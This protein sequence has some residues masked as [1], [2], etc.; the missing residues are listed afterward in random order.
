MTGLGSNPFA[1]VE[2]EGADGLPDVVTAKRAVAP[3]APALPAELVEMMQ[4]G[5]YEDARR[6]LTALEEEAKDVND[7]AYLGYLRG[8]SERLAGKRDAARETLRSA[9][10][11]APMSRWEAKIR[12]ELAGIEL[13]SGNLSVAEQLTRSE[14]ERLLAGDRKDRLAEVYHA[15]ARRLLEPDDPLVRP[16]PN[17]AYELLD[18]AR[19]LAKSALLRARF[20]DAMGRASLA[21]GNFGRA[22]ENFQTYLRDYPDG[23]DRFGVRMRLGEGQRRANQLLAARLTWTDLARAIERLKP[24]E[25]TAAINATFAQALAEIPSTYGI[26]NPP[27]DTSLNLGVAAVARFLQ[28][29]PAHPRAVREAFA[30]AAAYQAR[31]KHTQALDAYLRFLKEEGFKIETDDARRDWAA[32]SMTASYRVGVILQGQQ[33]F[34]EA[35]AAWKGY[36]ARFPNGPHGAQ[37]QRAILDTQLLIAVDQLGRGHFAEARAAWSEFV[38]Q[39][40]LDARLP[41]ILFQL[42][43]SYVKEKQ[44]DRAIAAWENLTSKFPNSEPAAHAQFEIAGIFETEKG[45]P[46]EA[47]E[48]FKKITVE[49]WRSQARQ[50]IAVMESKHLVTITPRTFRSGEQAHLEI[51]TRNIET[52]HFTAY[53]L[54]AEAYFRK[55]NELAN[56]ESLDIGLVAPDASWTVSVPGYAR[57]KPIEKS[58][59]LKKLELPGV[60]VVKV[61]D[62]KTFQAT[63]LVVGSDIDAIVK[64][65]RDQVLVFA[66]DMKTG[67]GRAGARVLIADKGQ[68][69]LEATT[70][71]DGI[72]LRDWE[73][74][75]ELNGTLS[76]LILDGPHVAGSH[77]TVPNQVAQGLSPRAY[78]YTD[79]PAYRPGQKVSVR[80]VVREVKDGQYANVP[81]AVY[82]FE[83]ADSRGRIIV[84]RPVALSEFG[85]FHESLPLD[86]SAPLGTYRVTVSQP[87]KSTFSGAFEVQSY[88]L[89]PIDLTFDVKQG[90]V[91]RGETVQTDLVARYQYGAP[92]ASRPIEI[93]LPDGRTLHGLTDAA[94]K[95]HVEFSTEGFAEEQ[96]LRLSARL[97]QDNVATAAL[98][99][100]AVRG[101]EIGLST[102]RDVYLDGESFP[103]RVTTTD[104]QGKPI[105]ES[106]TATLIKQVTTEG[107]VTERDVNRKT[108]TTDP[109]TGSASLTFRADDSQGGQYILRVAGTD[110]FGTAIVADRAVFISGKQDETKLRLLTDRQSYKVGEEAS[111]NLHSRGRAGTALLTW[112]ADRILSYRIVTL[113]E[114]DNGLAWSVDGAQF[115]N[116]TLT[117]TRMWQNVCDEAKLDI[118]VVRDL[119]VTV[120]PARPV[121][122]PGDPVELDITAVDQL[123]HAV[124]A[125]LSIAMV[126]Q[127]LLRLFNDK[128]PEIGPFFYNQTR[129]GAFSTEATNTFRYEPGTAPVSEAVV[130]EVEREAAIAS[131]TAGRGRVTELARAEARSTPLAMPAPAPPQTAAAPSAPGGG[132]GGMG[133]QMMAGAEEAK[134]ALGEAD[135]A[136]LSALGQATGSGDASAKHLAGASSGERFGRLRRQSRGIAYM[137][138]VSP[139]PREKYVETAYWNPAVVTDKEGKARITFKA[140]SALSEYRITARGVTGSDTLAGQ[141]SASLTVRKDFSVNLKVPTALTQ[142]DKPRLIAEV[143]HNG[144]K[145]V[146]SLRLATYAGG[147]DDVFLKAVELRGDGIDDVIF[148]PYEVP[149]G[150]SL[151]LTLT[152]TVGDVK[153]E[154][155]VE[156]LIHPWGIPVLASASGTSSESTTVFLGLPAGRTYENPDMLIALSPT[157]RRMLVE[158]AMGRDA[159]IYRL[160]INIEADSLSATARV[161]PPPTNTTADRA[162]DLLA[163]TSVLR[164]LRE[165]RAGAAPEAQ[166]LT[167]RIQ[168][169]VAELVAAQNPDGGWPWVAT[170]PPL[171]I[172]N[173]PAAAPSSDRLTSA[174]V[175][176]ALATAEPLGLSTD[177]KVLDQALA[178]LNQEFSR[179][180]GSDLESRAALVHA[181]STR[182]AASFET[183]NSLNRLRDHLSSPALAYLA[184][185]FANLDRTT[186]AGELL[187]ILGPRAKTETVAPGRTPRLY[188]EGT[189]RSPMIRGAA[190][191]TALVSLAYAR[192]RPQA[193]ELDRA[194]DWLQAHRVADGWLPHKAKGPA[195]ATL[196]AYYGR[197]QG[198]E[199]R[200]RLTVTVNETRVGVVDV[201]G[202]AEEKIIAV[203]RASLKTGQN[204]RIRFEMEGRGRFGYAATLAGFTREF[205]PDQDRTGRVAWIDRRVYHPASPELDGKVLPVGFGV[206]VNP[207]TFE[208]VATQVGLGGKARVAVTAF[209]NIPWN[210]PEW[211]RDF[212]V[213]QDRLPAGT[214]LI[215]GS[216]NTQATSYELANG[217]L[218]LYFPPGVNPGTTTYDV[219]GYLP[220]TYRALP[221]SVRS[222]YEPGRYHL[223]QPGEL[224][225]RASGEPSTDPYKP[226]P[227]EL[228]AW[229][230]AH[231]D[232]GRFAEAGEA[233]EPLYGGYTLRDDI[234][235][236][237]A[238]ML[239]LISIRAGQP[240][241]IVQYFEVVK[242]KSPELFLSFDQLLAIGA[243][244]RDIKEYERAMIVWRGL[245]EASYLEDARVG[246]LLRQRGKTLEA[247]AYLIDLWRTYPNTASIESDFFGLSQVLTQAASRAYTDPNLRREQAAA[248]I[249]RSE[250][251]LQTIRMIQVFLA[252]S[253]RNPMADEASLALLGAFIEL[254][255]FKS[256]VPL[257][258]RFAR[259]YPRSTYL[260]SFQYSEAL[261]QFHLG[262]YDRAIEVA[263]TI[264]RATYKDASGAEQPSPNKWQALYILG[265]IYDARRHPAKALEYYRQVADR[266]TDAAG[267]IA[268]YT[269][270]DLKVP[271]VSVVRPPALPAVAERAEAGSAVRGLRLVSIRGTGTGAERAADPAP[272]PGISVDYR[273]IAQVDVKA[274][275]VDLMQLYLTRRN[276]NGIAGIDLAGITPLVEKTVT[277]GD[278]ADYGD[279]ARSIDLPL[280]KDG[281][282]LVMLRGESLYASGIVLVSPIEMEVLEDAGAGR[283]RVTVRDAR[284]K[285]FLPKV[286]V[287]VIGSDN[288]QFLSGQTDLR[289]VF[290]ASGVRGVVTAVA[291]QGSNQYAFYRGTSYVGQ[292]AQAPNQPAAQLRAEP[293]PAPDAAGADQSLD[294]N[295]RL[296]N[297]INNDKQIQRLQQRYD[298]PAGKQKG[299]AAGGFR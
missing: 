138:D 87:G 127:S 175:F 143:H 104:A 115:P 213:V 83:V 199:D 73:K 285:D 33:K 206:A 225:V 80:G 151:R 43:E 116:F 9:L 18:Q 238:R 96:T 106:L 194:V 30:I 35:I 27:D 47:I 220:G 242:E 7:R 253:P 31:G 227:D 93:G 155:A 77:L 122:G 158:L 24:T 203:P 117:A 291:R 21:A 52:L 5:R 130:E 128:L 61:T 90:V 148:E 108:L 189:G 212:L 217:V 187:D 282:Y 70:G 20:L 133:G 196:S 23:A 14:A 111:V 71:P 273:N 192:V 250:L 4:A 247:T 125:E 109:T 243:A 280:T 230:K 268:S 290:V 211:E 57:Y 37:A 232:A 195:L 219:Y 94:G 202:T 235:K 193:S 162:A 60:Y 3:A 65:S 164:Y 293:V 139:S 48:R 188:W 275:P 78:I 56:V 54:S 184:L 88:Q 156:I 263:G 209:R 1:A 205:A 32:L 173:R 145:G 297:S 218:T 15:F 269:R 174:A 45:N 75:R 124:S 288:P 112:E 39:N 191:T 223:G 259:I 157:L 224:R 28:A 257:A 82:R 231:F 286:E 42:G 178:Y 44:F 107:R 179:T 284:S 255:D 101:F 38:A 10:Q 200:Y 216:V 34:A 123:G 102:P 69:V 267:A 100:L 278:G 215:E 99:R 141:T 190:E 121:V 295:L 256:V 248:G 166:R 181:M 207:N 132:M 221:A 135:L 197:A 66:Q 72:L 299:A 246:E 186:M 17:A 26:P 63:T 160:L 245:I 222:A 53:K 265:Q 95:Y 140:P 149:D 13:A 91:Y 163:A 67:R 50:R 129:T 19:D 226:T 81:R 36:L 92:L 137:R 237:A 283:V 168:G 79:R 154:L 136:D 12:F 142:G 264:A 214:T 249:T 51:T 118:Q 74:P 68:V 172:A 276:L 76:Y 201:Q 262:E 59:D 85:T 16:D 228:F 110:R 29:A 114:G 153:D 266:F 177:P 11:A 233:L 180:H 64:T 113:G 244:Y 292:E 2:W 6:A 144:V 8:I 239:L 120:K 210:V 274:Y 98:V 204:N 287:K 240:R 272:A 165:A 49:P 277:L 152:G 119:R 103:L 150:D 134:R 55:K 258:S 126:D 208:N 171:A 40:P 41:A 241:K 146:A 298:Q 182:H 236:D 169:L 183:A 229:G 84:A 89:E 261:A 25:R 131:N 234:A 22:I 62:E 294:A 58:Y 279:K 46:A 105:G 260:D 271:E 170:P 289:G 159:S 251:L 147:R 270:K 161:I 167:D 252:Q 254:E 97:P 86:S 185:T 281:A 296:Q 198:A 176:W